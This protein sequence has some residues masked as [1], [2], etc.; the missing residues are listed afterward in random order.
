MKYVYMHTMDG[1]PAEFQAD[2]KRIARGMRV[3]KVLPRSLTQVRRER[4]QSMKFYGES[5]AHSYGHVRI[6]AATLRP[7]AGLKP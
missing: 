1:D 7:S 2:E 4:R 5:N 3:I 6:M